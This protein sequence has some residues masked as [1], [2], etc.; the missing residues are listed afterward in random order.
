M[1]R[2]WKD[3]LERAVKTAAQAAIAVI[4][5][6]QVMGEV[7]WGMAVSSVVLATLLS[8]LTS[9]GSWKMGDGESASLVKPPDDGGN[10]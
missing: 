8:L 6:A 2:F 9:L 7:R 10:G 4:G 3:A 5:S 1:K